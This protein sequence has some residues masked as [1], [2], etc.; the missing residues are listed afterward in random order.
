MEIMEEYEVM[1]PYCGEWNTLLVDRSVRNQTYEED[2]EVCCQPMVID[3]SI[4][5][6]EEV[7]VNARQES[8]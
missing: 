3:V 4:G 8:E 7:Y 6:D 2:C 5:E 1:C